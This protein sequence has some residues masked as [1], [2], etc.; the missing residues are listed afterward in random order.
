MANTL[1]AVAVAPDLAK[2]LAL[3]EAARKALADWPGSHFNYR[4]SDVRQMLTMLDEAIAGLRA[5]AGASRFDISLA[6]YAGEPPAPEPTLPPPTVKDAIEQTLLAARITE[7]APERESLLKAAL[8]GLDRDGSTLPADW[9]VATRGE[10]KAALQKELLVDRTYQGLS[11]R[12]LA[13][14]EQRAHFADVHGIERLLL[15]IQ[16]RDAALGG[17]RPDD[18]S[19]LV[20]AVQVHLDA[21]RQV[22]LVRDRWALRAPDFRQYRAAISAPVDL[23]AQF[24]RLKPALEDIKSLAGSTP[25]TLV[26]VRHVVAQ[27]VRRASAI[28]PP[29]ELRAAHALA[30]ERGPDGRQR[31]PDSARGDAV[32]RHRARVGRLVGRRGRADARRA[33]Q[34][35]DPVTSSSAPT[36]VI[37]PRRTRLVRVADLHAFR[38]AIANHRSRP[39]RVRRGSRT[40]PRPNALAAR[41]RADAR[42]RAA[43]AAQHRERRAHRRARYRRCRISSRASSSTIGCARAC[44]IRR[45]V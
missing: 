33:R 17:K 23:L 42:R 12:A 26:A 4:A 15:T 40:W 32:G 31:R 20:A 44:R 28:A 37:T 3:V 8:T 24:A 22:R 45:G 14:A 5:A 43:A 41:R 21:A 36:S 11:K 9:V 10:A 19:A 34:E 1:N 16:R 30:R 2:R 25:G 27:I 6:A 18:I 13:Y 38:R 39:A 7:S 29:D 35:R